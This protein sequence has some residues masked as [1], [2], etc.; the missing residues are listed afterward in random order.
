[1][2]AVEEA[3]TGAD[4]A[5]VDDAVG[6]GGGVAPTAVEVGRGA[7]GSD[8]SD[9]GPQ[10]NA[11]LATHNATNLCTHGSFTERIGPRRRSVLQL[12]D[13]GCTDAPREL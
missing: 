7:V 11:T 4:A 5:E 8:A 10:P 3:A 1:M 9:A 12:F 6:S 2:L 13:A